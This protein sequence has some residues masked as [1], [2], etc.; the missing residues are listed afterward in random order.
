MINVK[1]LIFSITLIVSTILSLYI[2]SEESKKERSVNLDANIKVLNRGE[3]SITLK[4]GYEKI[5][6]LQARKVESWSR[7]TP[8]SSMRVAQYKIDYIKGSGQLVVF[9]GIGGSP[10]ENIE[11]W[12]KQFKSESNLSIAEIAS[13]WEIVKEKLNIKFVHF[14]GTYMKSDMRMNSVTEELKDYAL[15]AAIISGANEPYYFKMTGPSSLIKSQI[16]L[17]ESFINSIQK[18]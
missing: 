3:D 7:E 17:F 8:S 5:G 6:T 18:L 15:L 4:P 13:K 12:Y 16:S 9:S 2:Y 11:R 10:D 1:Y 14:K